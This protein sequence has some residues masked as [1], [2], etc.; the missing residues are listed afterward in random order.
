MPYRSSYRR[1][2]TDLPVPRKH[3]EPNGSDGFRLLGDNC[4]VGFGCDYRA[5]VR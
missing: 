1:L 3:L 4:R 2:M 5:G